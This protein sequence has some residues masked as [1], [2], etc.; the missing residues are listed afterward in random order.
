MSDIINPL[1]Q[2]LNT[3]PQY[4]GLATFIISAGESVAIIG[5]LVPGSITMTAIGALAGAGVIPLYETIL[6]AILGAIVG[7]GI[8]YWM[9]YYFKDRLPTIWPF[10]NFPGFLKGGERFVHKY[11]Y[12]SVFI[13]RFVGPV[14]AI[15]PLVAGMLGM[16][17]LKFTIANVTSAIGWAPAYMLPGIMVGAASL[18]LPPDIAIHV[19]LVLVL[20]TL[21]VLLCMWFV[22]K[23]IQLFVYHTTH[24]Q[25]DIWKWLSK[26]RYF[27]FLTE[28]LSH[29][30]DKK[31]RGQLGLGF[32]FIDTTIIFVCLVI[33]VKLSGAHNL[34][35]N[36]VTFHF[37]RGIRDVS[38]DPVAL[39][40]TF[41]GQKEVLIPVLGAICVW[42]YWIN[43]KRA[44][45]HALALGIITAG[46]IFV[47]K[48]LAMIARPWGIFQSP[49]TY[50]MPSGHTTIATALYMGF[51]ILL[52]SYMSR[53]KK[54]LIYPCAL[55]VI[56][57][58]S[59]SRLY[60]G[61]HWFTDVL[62]GWLLGTAVLIFVI[63]SYARKKEAPLNALQ[64]LSVAF[65]SLFVSY[66]AYHYYAYNKMLHAYAQIEYPSAQVA[67]DE[68]WQKNNGI[69]AYSAS[70]FGFPSQWINIEWIGNLTDIEKSLRSE[71]WVDPPARDFIGILHRIA[72]VK[73][74]EYLPL[75]SPQYLDKNPELEL[76][77]QIDADK[78]L[79]VVRLWASSRYIA[80]TN[81]PL[82]VGIVGTAPRA[83]SWLRPGAMKHFD[84]DPKLVFPQSL[85]L[86]QWEMKMISIDR[87]YREQYILLIR[88]KTA[89]KPKL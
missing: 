18:E 86:N 19:V 69:P 49:E 85:T 56:F 88:E 7:D 62:A 33:Y 75:I 83:Y 5:T 46:S 15:V 22:Y 50:S 11:G 82:W 14:R 16:P 6:W 13:G 32:Y 52:A 21:F 9:G 34:M 60:L 76:V 36:D 45:L 53:F 39:D 59:T 66:S 3:N 78:N 23:L 67:M 10:R 27:S 48:H 41:L 31:T 20:M 28:W 12:M 40:I 44:A 80:A 72:D 8:S 24:M 77:R 4:A 51:A 38:F 87:K 79:L 47:I 55:L 61:A 68:W 29:H 70:L 74:N 25:E 65:I 42:L 54:W 35:I 89:T 64:L 1:L 71:G 73:S 43:R 30:S 37:F 84:V 26:S 63:I 2:W 58:I 17:P 57:L 81:T